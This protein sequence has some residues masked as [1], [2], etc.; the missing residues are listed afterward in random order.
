MVAGEQETWPKKH[1]CLEKNQRVDVVL[2]SPWERWVWGPAFPW[3]GAAQNRIA[4]CSFW[5]TRAKCF[6]NSWT[7]R[8][9]HCRHLV[10]RT[11]Q[12]TCLG[13]WARTLAY[14]RFWDLIPASTNWASMRRNQM[15]GSSSSYGQN[16]T[17]VVAAAVTGVVRLSWVI[18]GGSE[19][20]GKVQRFVR[21]SAQEEQKMVA[22]VVQKNEPT[23]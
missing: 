23:D 2:T 1:H 12:R 18:F 22:T 11:S 3:V 4:I 5:T 15:C 9:T 16:L 21:H 17:C 6:S 20:A 7:I 19:K 14:F 8:Q 10:S 13:R